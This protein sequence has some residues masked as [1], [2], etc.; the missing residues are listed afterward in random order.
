MLVDGVAVIGIADDECVDAME[1]GHDKFEDAKRVHG[2]ESASRE[3]PGKDGSQ[4]AP[5][6]WTIFQVGGEPRQGIFKVDFGFAGESGI[7]ISD[8]GEGGQCGVG[9]VLGRIAGAGEGDAAS[10]EFDAGR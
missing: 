1:L 5:Q 3:W 6:D 2:A 4:V 8:R 9:I 10:A 7:G